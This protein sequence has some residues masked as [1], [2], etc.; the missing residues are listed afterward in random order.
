MSNNQASNGYY[1]SS[2][3]ESSGTSP[4]LNFNSGTPNTTASNLANALSVRCVQAFTTTLLI[5]YFQ[6]LITLHYHKLP[7]FTPSKEWHISGV[8]KVKA[9]GRVIH[10]NSVTYRHSKNRRL[11]NNV[12]VY[13]GYPFPLFGLPAFMPSCR[14][15]FTGYFFVL[16]AA[17][18]RDNDNGSSRNQ[19]TFGSYWSSKLEV[20]SSPR[21]EFSSSSASMTAISLAYALS[22]RCVQAFTAT[23]LILY[24]Q[25]LITF[26]HY[27]LPTFT[28]SKEWHI[29][30]V[31]KAK[32][33]GRGIS[34]FSNLPAYK[35]VYGRSSYRECQGLLTQLYKEWLLLRSACGWSPKQQ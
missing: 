28:P 14:S 6:T 9:F 17:G 12:Y 4:R 3:L 22:V 21:L 23:L 16:P 35:G 27:K 25:M 29:S 1:W 2:A 8:P 33:F 15:A 26:H 18:Y 24:F 19:A 30:G 11:E 31:P 10:V 7:T 20:G 5:L 32:V 34:K 13:A